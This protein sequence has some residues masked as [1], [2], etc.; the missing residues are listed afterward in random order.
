LWTPSHHRIERTALALEISRFQLDVWHTTDFI[1]P[2]F[3]ARHFIASIHDLTFLHYPEFLTAESRRYYNAQIHAAVARAD[4]ILTI[5]ESSRQDL[6]TMLGVSPDK[7][8]VQI[9]GTDASFQPQSP[10]AITKTRT[11]L[12]LPETYI[13]SLSTFEPRKNIL[14]LLDAYRGLLQTMPDAPSL[15]IA[16]NRGWLFEETR[17]KIKQMN[18]ENNILLREKVPQEHLP[19]L[20]AGAV[21]LVMPSFYEGFGLPALEAMA[22]GTVPVVSN[23]SSLPEVVGNVGAQIDPHDPATLQTALERVITDDAWRNEQ[24]RA[25]LERATFFTWDK[26][27]KTALAVYERVLQ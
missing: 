8:T 16:G 27:A 13:L 25:A 14:G 24:E 2:R 21:A 6:V 9:L 19:A 17:A 15:V 5:S 12:D 22:C 4:H 26:A 7:V 18:I 20:Y 23:V 10:A 11:A 1:P 3:G